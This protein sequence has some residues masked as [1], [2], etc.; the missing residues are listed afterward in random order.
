MVDALLRPPRNYEN[1]ET[2]D[3]GAV[4]VDLST[5]SLAKVR[6]EQMKNGEIAN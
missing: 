6:K 3:V 2:C 4:T 5:R 1:R